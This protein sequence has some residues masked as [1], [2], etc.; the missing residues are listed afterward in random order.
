[1]HTWTIIP[2]KSGN[3]TGYK[4]K[5]KRADRAG[6]V[7]ERSQQAFDYYFDCVTDAKKHGYEPPIVRRLR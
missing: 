7:V 5:W 1:M 6:A 2:V 4:W 3:E